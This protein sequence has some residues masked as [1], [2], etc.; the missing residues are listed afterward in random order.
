MLFQ[1]ALDGENMTDQHRAY[2]HLEEPSR[3]P[4]TF[5]E[6]ARSAL[7][8][9]LK[10]EPLLEINRSGMDPS[11]PRE[12]RCKHAR[13]LGESASSE[14]VFS[15][16]SDEKDPIVK[17]ALAQAFRESYQRT[18]KYYETSMCSIYTIAGSDKVREERDQY[19]REAKKMAL[20]LLKGVP[21]ISYE[22]RLAIQSVIDDQ[23]S[24]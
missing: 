4:L 10:L 24:P 18:L 9:L 16:L 22:G 19:S 14:L 7:K 8:G 6:K 5:S 20:C 21:G 17:D 23:P 2:R 15:Y 13:K 1:I 3:G 11:L 12:E